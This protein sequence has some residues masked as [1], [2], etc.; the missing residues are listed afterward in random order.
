MLLTWEF[1]L[2]FIIKANM[3]KKIM[4]LN[5]G[6]IFWQANVNEASSKFLTS[7]TAFESYKLKRVPFGIS[8]FPGY[9]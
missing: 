1:S 4:E 2:G 7:N 5:T 8:S 9:F 6:Y 3:K